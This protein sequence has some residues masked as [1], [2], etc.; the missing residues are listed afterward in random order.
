M[1]LRD[2]HWLLEHGRLQLTA[3][4]TL[5]R[6]E[7]IWSWSVRSLSDYALLLTLGGRGEIAVDGV[8]QQLRK[9]VC[10]FLR[11]TCRIDAQQNPSYPLFLF[12]ARFE[13]L[14]HQENPIS[15]ANLPSPPQVVLI[16]NTRHL[17]SLADLIVSRSDSRSTDDPLTHDAI[18][19]LLRLL[20]ENASRHAGKFD[21]R[22]YEALRA[23]ENDLARKWTIAALAKE[24]G[25]SP[26][27]FARAFSKMMGE[28]PIHYVIRRRLEEAKRQIQQS[29]LSIEEIAINLGYNDLSF[30]R[31][32]FRRRVG[33]Q[34]EELRSNRAF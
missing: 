16:Q 24:A 27:V 26:G 6:C 2:G 34:P 23:I 8:V 25:V 21:P 3:A 1:A 18:N 30:F 5:Y 28:P 29:S 14:D 15:P 17:E 4:P 22:A 9:G 31:A 20:V 32:L 19:M 10:L 33:Y 11:P 7:P 13:F 12:I